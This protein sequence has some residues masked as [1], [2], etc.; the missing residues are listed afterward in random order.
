MK[1]DNTGKNKF[2]KFESAMIAAFIALAV[3]FVGGIVFS[4][5]K[6]EDSPMRSATM[7]AGNGTQSQE[8][9]SAEMT[10][11]IESLE[12][13]A[14]QAP[15]KPEGWI[16][17]GPACFD[18]GLYPKA[19]EAYENALKIQPEN[20]DVWTNLGVMYRRNE[21][22]EKAITSFE[23]AQSIS[24]GHEVSLFNKGIVL[25]HDMNDMVR[26]KEAWEALLK[27]NPAA[28]TPN[29]M[30]IQDLVE[31]MTEQM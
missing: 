21:E 6:M 28:T 4:A 19:I 24:P 20:A 13:A 27:V 3:G 16:A 22:P 31:K 11:E 9:M 1:Q 17:L 15:E 14:K 26:A 8:T 5:F 18:F 30:P 25:M 29:G 23:K 10:A 2:V 12:K 7:V